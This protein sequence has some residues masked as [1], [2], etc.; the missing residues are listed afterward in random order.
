MTT[1]IEFPCENGVEL[2]GTMTA[3]DATDLHRIQCKDC[4]RYA[5]LHEHRDDMYRDVATMHDLNVA[6]LN[7]IIGIDNMPVEVSGDALTILK[8]KRP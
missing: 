6:A 5:E 1:Y 7:R 4:Q 2:D 3:R 8:E